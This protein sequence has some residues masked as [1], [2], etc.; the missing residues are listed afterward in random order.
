MTDRLR[1][2]SGNRVLLTD[3]GSWVLLAADAG[4]NAFLLEGPFLQVE[5]ATVLTLETG[6]AIDL[7]SPAFDQFLLETGDVLLLED[8]PAPP[9]GTIIP[10]I[11]HHLRQ[12]GVS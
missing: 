6:V 7:E 5:D 11:I 4:E 1:L 8:V 3:G 9:G 10:I 12:Q 2:T